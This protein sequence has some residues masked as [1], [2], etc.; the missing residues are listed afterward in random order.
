MLPL[1]IEI[2]IMTNDILSHNSHLVILLI[3]VHSLRHH[4]IILQKIFLTRRIRML[5]KCF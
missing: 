1:N 2:I 3:H 5:L 4:N